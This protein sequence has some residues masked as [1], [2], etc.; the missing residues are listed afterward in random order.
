MTCF[1]V[2]LTLCFVAAVLV[3]GFVAVRLF[4]EPCVVL[5][6]GWWGGGKP[7]NQ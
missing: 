7:Y 6:G 3:E 5:T 2:V 4:A 1:S